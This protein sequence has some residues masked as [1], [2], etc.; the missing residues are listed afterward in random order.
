M[1]NNA[2]W[3]GPGGPLEFGKRE[4]YERVF[5]VNLFGPAEVMRVFL[6]LLKHSQG[7]IV[8]MASIAGILAITMNHAYVS[9]KYAMVGISDA[10]R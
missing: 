7:R 3:N 10:V 6:P 5:Q 2:G 4:D 8:N 9:S 1:V